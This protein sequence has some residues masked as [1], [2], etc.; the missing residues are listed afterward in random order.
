M[1]SLPRDLKEEAHLMELESMGFTIVHDAIPPGLL[2]RLKI[3]HRQACERIRQCKPKADWSW[4]S[5]N[6][7][8]VD[9]W[10]L[11]ALDPCY[12]ELLTLP[13]IY[14]IC[15]R[16]IIEGRG[17]PGMEPHPA[18]PVLV[19]EMAQHAPG[20]T[21][22]G[23]MWHQDGGSTNPS[24]RCTFTLN[25]LA[26]DGGGT[27][28]MAGSHTP[29]SNEYGK[30]L[31]SLRTHEYAPPTEGRSS[32]PYDRSPRRPHAMPN[33]VTQ[34]G[35]AGSCMIN[36]T[37]LW[38]TR[39]PNFTS[40]PRD[41]VW[42]IFT[43]KQPVSA[44]EGA[45]GGRRQHHQPRHYVEWV[46]THGSV[47]DT[48]VA[49]LNRQKTP[50]PTDKNCLA[51]PFPQEQLRALIGQPGRW[52]FETLSAEELTRTTAAEPLWPGGSRPDELLGQ[53]R[54]WRAASKL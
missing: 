11:Y 18:G 33:A 29:G 52:A 2:R 40:Q 12:E 54:R 34:H 46:Q 14:N 41:V 45:H 22:G 31:N 53:P 15:Q 9:Y 1:L 50:R 10:R 30:V 23:Q 17:G 36:W 27:I 5:D 25:A 42:Q 7:G 20:H 48:R 19:H 13:S 44:R 43:R 4:E 3:C 32:A 35:K 26:H 51:R 8:V 39:P 24:L 21:P 28:A 6:E 16:A 49:P 37:S 38:H 47:R